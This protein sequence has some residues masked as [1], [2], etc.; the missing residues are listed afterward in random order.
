MRGRF[1][2][3]PTAVIATVLAN[4]VMPQKIKI[5]IKDPVGVSF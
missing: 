5:Q 2:W 1:F 3:K 4:N